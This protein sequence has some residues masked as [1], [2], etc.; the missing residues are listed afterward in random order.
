MGPPTR[1]PGNPTYRS[2]IAAV[3]RPG[4]YH[5]VTPAYLKLYARRIFYATQKSGVLSD[6][7]CFWLLGYREKILVFFNAGM[8]AVT[9]ALK[10]ILKTGY[11]PYFLAPAPSPIFWNPLN[12]HNGH[13]VTWQFLIARLVVCEFGADSW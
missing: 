3:L 4:E 6:Y 12:G 9:H 2:G 13:S 10:S 11:K 5:R 7:F 8:Y 1:L